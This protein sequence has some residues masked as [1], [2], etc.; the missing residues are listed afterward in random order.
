MTTKSPKPRAG[1]R[2]VEAKRQA[3][4]P[5]AAVAAKPKSLTPKQEAFYAAYLATDNASEAYRRAYDCAR[6]KPA[7]V[8]NNAAAL[9]RH[10]EIAARLA[11]NAT[12][13]RSVAEDRYHVTKERVI[14]ELAL[15]AFARVDDVM[16]WGPDGAIA[17]ASDSLTAEQLAAVGEV[18]E[19]RDKF[20]RVM[21]RVKMHDKQAALDKLGRHVGA[22]KSEGEEDAR[23]AL[24]GVLKE[25]SGATASLL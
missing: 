9:L 25:L 15:I 13:L 19:R 1:A 2:M 5:R 7:T 20:G 8:N 18:S 10:S 16:S 23:S 22:W 17:K 21:M 6:M 3:K 4:K 11:K 12:R 14:A 24:L